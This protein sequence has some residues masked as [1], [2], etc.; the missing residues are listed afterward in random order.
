VVKSLI[1]SKPD[2]NK[3]KRHNCRVASGLARPVGVTCHASALPNGPAF[4][5]RGSP[6]LDGEG[7]AAGGDIDAGGSG[8]CRRATG[9][10]GRHERSEPCR[11][12]PGRRVPATP[13]AVGCGAASPYLRA[14]RPGRHHRSN[15]GGGAPPGPPAGRPCAGRSLAEGR[16]GAA[17]AGGGGLADGFQRPPRCHRHPCHP[18]AP[19]PARH[20]AA[21]RPGAGDTVRQHRGGAGGA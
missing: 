1:Q 6:S 16:R 19:G 7:P 21:R 18:G 5:R 2:R 20:G 12:G 13:S 9:R 4:P 8:P 11:A 17:P 3:A 10:T 14:A 15:A